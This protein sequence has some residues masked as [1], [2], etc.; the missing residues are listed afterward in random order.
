MLIHTQ[1]TEIEKGK[2]N[3]SRD[4]TRQE[5]SRVGLSHHCFSLLTVLSEVKRNIRESRNKNRKK[6]VVTFV[7]KLPFFFFC[8]RKR[9]HDVYIIYDEDYCV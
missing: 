9:K 5:K 8:K 2:G 7:K 6:N 4:E 3:P 1:N